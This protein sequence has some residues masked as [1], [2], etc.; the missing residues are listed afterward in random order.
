LRTVRTRTHKL[1]MDL[2]SGAGEMY[3]LQSDPDEMVNLFDAPEA[4]DMQ[5]KLAEYI[6]SR[7]QDMLPDQTPVGTA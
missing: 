5:A 6:A 3:D 7:P 2:N 4:A 1:T